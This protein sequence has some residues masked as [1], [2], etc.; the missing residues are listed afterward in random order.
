MS[1]I[2]PDEKIVVASDL[3]GYYQP[4]EKVVKHYGDG[5]D[6]YLLN[7]DLIG[8]GPSTARV[9]DIAQDINADINLGN[10]ELYLLAGM[11]QE[12]PEA[13]QR[14]QGAAKIFGTRENLLGA[15]AS[16][17]GVDIRGKDR[18]Y[19]IENLQDKMMERGHLQMLAQA[20]MYFEGKDFVAVHAGL[21]DTGL[22]LQKQE[23][24]NAR[25]DLLKN[26]G[27][28]EFDEPPQITS[29]PLAHQQE[30]FGATN[31]IVVTG[32]AHEPLGDRITA[33]G[34]RVR[35]GS[36]LKKNQPLHVWQSWDKE[37]KSFR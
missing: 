22:L 19:M 16:S 6:R 5:P 1:E 8:A 24:F 12:D 13:R 10:W 26:T 29:L 25:K 37:I 30:A 3:H 21:T 17:Y 15:I 27:E 28:E 33:D 35:I 4:L 11:L 36:W 23:M 34:A 7:G 9:L 20:A 2:L 14:I 31:K 32:H 18:S